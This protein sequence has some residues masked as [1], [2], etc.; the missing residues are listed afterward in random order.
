MNHECTSLQAHTWAFSHSEDWG[1]ESYYQR[2]NSFTFSDSLKSRIILI[3]KEK[4]LYGRVGGSNA[5]LQVEGMGVKNNHLRSL[6]TPVVPVTFVGV[7]NMF[8]F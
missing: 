8:N 1:S 6:Q 4:N 3:S 5:Y 2:S 7:M